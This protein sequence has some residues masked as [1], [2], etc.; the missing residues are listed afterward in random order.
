MILVVCEMKSEEGLGESI[1]N[2]KFEIRRTQGRK[3]PCKV[4][5]AEAE[6]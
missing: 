4:I 1:R 5:M 3:R 2:G 6:T